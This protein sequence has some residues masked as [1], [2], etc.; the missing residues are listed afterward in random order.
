M[1]NIEPEVAK[2]PPTTPR[3]ENAIPD[4]R[5]NGQSPYY[6]GIARR[7]IEDHIEQKRLRKYLEDWA[8]S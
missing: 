3:M 6:N 8:D 4:G 7:K 2:D 1:M 5:L